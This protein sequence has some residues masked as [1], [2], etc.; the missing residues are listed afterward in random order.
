MTRTSKDVVEAEKGRRTSKDVVEAEKGR[1][2]RP[3]S[4][5]QYPTKGGAGSQR[6]DAPGGHWRSL[7]AGLHEAI[8]DAPYESSSI[9]RMLR[10]G[11][12]E[13]DSTEMQMQAVALLQ[14]KY[15]SLHWAD[16]QAA[17]PRHD[18]EGRSK[19][20]WTV[21]P[22]APLRHDAKDVTFPTK[23]VSTH[24][25]ATSSTALLAVARAIK[26]A[27]FLHIFGKGEINGSMLEN[28]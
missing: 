12:A 3:V 27:P 28:V 11:P 25:R 18:V 20:T 19:V 17:L 2:D 13:E 5:P 26:K 10:E 23:C 6:G 1:R 24:K 22:S 14:D 7:D 21:R 9:L 4:Q 15:D 16:T 8:P